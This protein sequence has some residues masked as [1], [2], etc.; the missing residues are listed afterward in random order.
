[1][2]KE[3]EGGLTVALL[4]ASFRETCERVHADFLTR[5]SLGKWTL[6]VIGEQYRPIATATSNPHDDVDGVTVEM[7]LDFSFPE[8]LTNF[9]ESQHSNST[10]WDSN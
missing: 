1:M 7:A 9:L 3:L 8:N 4:S 10:R 6:S 5:H 2:V